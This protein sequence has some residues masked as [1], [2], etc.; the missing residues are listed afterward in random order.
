MA[1][2]I[3]KA[4]DIDNCTDNRIILRDRESFAMENS[5][6]RFSGSNNVLYLDKGVRLGKSRISFDAN[7]SIVFLC[8]SRNRYK[9]NIKVHNCNAC[10]LGAN[11]Y[12]N[13][14]LNIICSE[15][16]NVFI[17]SDAMLSFGIWIRTADPHLIYSADT[18]ERINPSGSVFIGDHVWIG[19]N[20]LILKGSEIHSGSILGG[21]AVLAGK[22]IPSNASCA[23]NPARIVSD[24]IF[25]ESPCVHAWTEDT[26]KK[27][28]WF[29]GG[30]PSVFTED[31]GTVSF[32]TVD[33]EL[34]A[35]KTAE[36]KL[37]YLLELT[38]VQDRNRFAGKRK[39]DTSL[40]QETGIWKKILKSR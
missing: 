10:C 6:I 25:W 39:K 1:Q 14:V 40:I 18:K 22:E 30:R 20:A 4:E 24:N 2:I 36:E 26:T 12:Y 31:T 9:V 28:S 5:E 8:E 13:G 23:G 17:G 38:A 34:T 19:Q 35:R 29:K 3:T 37:E 7:N 27:H 21:G 16:R 32:R 15:G 11:G 33:N